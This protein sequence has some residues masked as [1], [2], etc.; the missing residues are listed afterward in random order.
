MMQK[1]VQQTDVPANTDVS[2]VEFSPNERNTLAR[3]DGPHR[4]ALDCQES[5]WLNFVAV[6][7]CHARSTT[8]SEWITDNRITSGLT[9]VRLTTIPT[10]AAAS[11]IDTIP[12]VTAAVQRFLFEVT[13][14]QAPDCLK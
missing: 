11:A 3:L 4:E 5:W 12:A 14:G 2:L 13:V 6:G 9:V 1:P 10:A 7:N 8:L